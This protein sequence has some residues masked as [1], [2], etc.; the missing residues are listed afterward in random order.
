M[1]TKHRSPI[2][3]TP[4]FSLIESR[5]R[6]KRFG[7]V[8]SRG[9]NGR[10]D[11][12]AAASLQSLDRE[13]TASLDDFLLHNSFSLTDKDLW[14]LTDLG[15]SSNVYEKGIIS[16]PPEL[17]QALSTSVA[18]GIPGTSAD[19]RAR[20][21]A[22]GRNELQSAS[23]L[24]VLEL[25]LDAMKDPTILTLLVAGGVSLLLEAALQLNTDNDPNF[26]EG[27]GIL[28][29]VLVVV[30]VSAGQNWQK[31]K[32]YKSLRDAEASSSPVRCIRAGKEVALT[33]S[34]L[35]VGDIMLLEPGDI[36]QADGILLDGF[37]VSVD[38]SHL[39]GESDDVEKIAE[40]RQVLY[41]GSK[42]S[43]GVGRAVV[44]AVGQSTQAGSVNKM[45]LSIQDDSLPGA[46]GQEQ[47]QLQRQLAEYAG[48]VG[49]L[50][51][52]AAALA[53]AAA[54]AQF[55][56]QTFVVSGNTWSWTY[57]E[58]YLHTLTTGISLVVVAVPEGLP[59]ASTL[60]L[61][62][63]AR[64]LLEEKNLVRHIGAAET[65]GCATVICSDKTGTLTTNQMT[66]ESLWIGGSMV[67]MLDDSASSSE[68]TLR[69]GGESGSVPPALW[70]M[71]AEGIRAN[72]TATFTQH[73]DG[74]TMRSGSR[75][76][77]ALLQ[78]VENNSTHSLNGEQAHRIVS[79]MPFSS[80]RKTMATVIDAGGGVLRKHTK[81]A[82]DIVMS[83]CT[84]Y[85]SAAGDAVPL[86]SEEKI[87]VLSRLE[88]QGQRVLCLALKEYA[89]T[90][91]DAHDE[92][93]SESE[94]ETDLVLLAVV[95]IKDPLRK[96]V[97]DAIEKCHRAGID[98]KL[99]TG[100]SRGTAIAIAQQCG[101]LPTPPQPPP[102][103]ND[104]PLLEEGAVLEG[105]EFRRLAFSPDG[106]LDE[107]AFLKIW[108][109]VKV[110]A[111]CSP[112]DKLA[113]VQGA[114]RFTDDV[115]AVTGDGTNDAPA[116]RAAAVG[117]AMKS[118]TATARSAADIVVL[119]DNFA[120]I[121]SA[122]LWGRGVYI[123]VT[124]FLQFQ[125]TGNIVAVVLA[126][127]G[128]LALQES[129]L[130]AVQMLW[131]NL[132]I[133]SLASVALATEPPDDSLLTLPPF[134]KDH[135]FINQKTLKHVSGQATWQLGV[136]LTLLFAPHLF[137][138]PAHI[139]GQ[140]PSLHHTLVFNCFVTM[141][142]FNQINARQTQDTNPFW[143]GL[144]TAPLFWGVLLAEGLLQA[145][146]VHYGGR[147]FSVTPLSLD[148]WLLCGGFG[149]SV[150]ALHEGL[151]RI[152]V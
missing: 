84:S 106:T 11:C 102:A 145:G 18:T 132:I 47:T 37:D 105:P 124:R 83:M 109:R 142:L 72:S 135:A 4:S 139:V 126:V 127:V 133:D 70:D 146:I 45:L 1:L 52:L 57:L 17:L 91:S 3:S 67:P 22:F 144:D 89:L 21:R 42:V 120:S 131:L 125:L 88:R 50:G 76:E 46:L 60:A 82:P 85:L 140:G 26:L 119:D 123:S 75:T 74:N 114:Q 81:G 23:D 54:A 111:R 108:P 7:N 32:Q 137:G 80:A 117:F 59:L 29:A 116:L 94:G 100:D 115:V 98:V 143:N 101:I 128:S 63:A 68:S 24:S 48:T 61:A 90:S 8:W 121:K 31:Q 25:I 149:L 28:S 130:T 9:Y 112:G 39:T 118:G 104:A 19:L 148:H 78:L 96:E 30:S 44:T 12:G 136:T 77:I 134:R 152:R 40:V 69:N 97:P 49:Q 5:C 20:I 71:L 33:A 110:M 113:L 99:L 15:S 10:R 73:E 66:V 92:S 138:V 2:C 107:D 141:S 147:A 93:E 65:M 64:Q 95:G 41:A 151:R 150:L 14:K 53:T 6:V 122:V 51:L 13:S 129:P 38:E 55:T 35:V 58:N 16:D 86:S 56:I 34:N 79:Q 43:S 87:E 103:E 36:L 27:F 62:Y